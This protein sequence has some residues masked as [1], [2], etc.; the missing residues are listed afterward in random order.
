LL[1]RY[2]ITEPNLGIRL[3]IILHALFICILIALKQQLPTINN[4]AQYIEVANL[5]LNADQ[6]SDIVSRPHQTHRPI[7][8]EGET[9]VLEKPTSAVPSSLDKN[10]SIE[11]GPQTTSSE[12]ANGPSGGSLSSI[13]EQGATG[14]GTG[15]NGGNIG[16]GDGG[17]WN[18]YGRKLQTVC[19]QFKFYP[20]KAARQGWQGE[21]EV[22]IHFQADG[23]TIN[24]TVD[25]S[26]QHK[27]LDNQAIEMVKKGLA[28]LPLPSSYFGRDVKLIMPVEFKLK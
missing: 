13:S 26:S 20:V 23:K 5:K 21:V 1:L 9:N 15:L 16:V 4:E 18:D 19:S 22:L 27:I 25:K 24:I 7:P 2:K 8:S 28:E 17:F 3:S 10:E 14:T 6:T 12:S 11:T